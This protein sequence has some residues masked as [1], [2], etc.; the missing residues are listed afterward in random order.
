MVF[1]TPNKSK[2]DQKIVTDRR[3]WREE[4]TGETN[5]YLDERN[6]RM[7]RWYNGCVRRGADGNR[8]RSTIADVILVDGTW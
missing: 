2:V 6:Q 4:R 5:S 7:A 1:W 3:N 8:L